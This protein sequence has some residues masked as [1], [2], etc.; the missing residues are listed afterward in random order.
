MPK[1]DKWLLKMRDMDASDLHLTEGFP[2]KFRIHGDLRPTDE[3]PI[4]RENLLD[5]LPELCNTEQWNRFEEEHDMDFAYDIPGYARFRTN[6]LV[7]EHGL[8]AV[9]RR[10]PDRMLSFEELGLPNSVLQFVELGFGLILV[11][12]LLVNFARLFKGLHSYA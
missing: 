12:L 1:M 2:P 7:Q 6:Y 4:T 5:M 3:P 11:T 9:L 8:G 10:I